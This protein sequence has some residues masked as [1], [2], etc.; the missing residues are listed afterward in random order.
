[1]TV[2]KRIRYVPLLLIL[3]LLLACTALAAES[4]P[5]ALEAAGDGQTAVQEP[6]QAAQAPQPGEDGGTAAA[7]SEEGGEEQPAGPPETEDG[8][9]PVPPAP[10]VTPAGTDA[11]APVTGEPGGTV[12]L[13][14]SDRE[15]EPPANAEPSVV[16]KK[17]EEGDRFGTVSV[18]KT[19]DGSWAVTDEVY[20]ASQGL[21]TCINVGLYVSV[22]LIFLC[23]LLLCGILMRKAAKKRN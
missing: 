6:D 1:M 5:E 21:H 4:A 3:S 7:P 12:S 11:A 22:C 15:Q 13:N 16:L 17:A 2:K 18:E 9:S 10:E 23:C 19:E 20:Y 8:T 14:P